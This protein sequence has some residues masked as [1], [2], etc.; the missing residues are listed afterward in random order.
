MSTA[1]RKAFRSVTIAVFLVSLL[2]L[3]ALPAGAASSSGGGTP[4]A[5]G[6]LT[7]AIT[8]IQNLDPLM[9]NSDFD[10][11]VLSQIFN[12]LVRTGKD[13]QPIPDLAT[14]WENPDD[15]T[16]VFHLRKGVY[17]HDGNQVFARG[18]SRE[19]T[20]QDVKYTLERVLDPKTKSPFAGALASI[21]SIQAVDKYTVKIKTKAPDPFL[22]DAIRLAGIAIVP[23]EA[24]EKLGDSFAKNP[25][26]SGPF[27]FVEFVP[28]DHVTLVRNDKYWKK[29]YLDKVIFRVIPD[30]AVATISLESGD[31][32]VSL[33]L[34][35]EEIGRLR[36]S[37]DITLYRSIQ[38]WYRG[39]G[40]NLKKE[41]FDDLRVRKAI[42]MA[43]DI[44]SAVDNVF[45]K[46]AERAYGQVGPGIVGY[47]P[48]LKSLWKYDPAG[49]KKLLAEAGFRPGP[50]GIM[51]KN[52]QKLSFDIKTMNEPGR[53]KI[54]TILATQLKAVGIDAKVVTQET[55][56]WVSDLQSGNTTVFMD[57]AYSGPTGLHALF[58]S[59][60]IGNSNTHFYA[61][62]EVDA[63]LDKGSKTVNVKAREQIWKK[64]Q[65]MIME[66]VPVIPLYFEF[67][68]TATK[69]NVKDFIPQQWNLNLVS[70]E[71]NVWLAR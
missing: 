53:V 62:K 20:A 19:V 47:D 46:N 33:S 42:A 18:K 6:T 38:G 28:D 17:W 44:D 2:V 25:V 31:V 71:N 8:S 36:K 37:K 43:I 39:L 32:D 51:E 21:D 57:F 1:L 29:P 45:G 3:A 52:G 26:G 54:V 61:N 66:D 35:P 7:I 15:T 56:T 41:P 10:Y 12:S 11:A 34:P 59:S 27:K 48:S 14:S 22:L 55:G 50:D 30:A 23:K 58:H 13:G 16:W 65:R 70:A 4:K 68:Y 64:A 69:A 63:L 24:I 60:N 67:G 49:A 5:G 9:T 40:F